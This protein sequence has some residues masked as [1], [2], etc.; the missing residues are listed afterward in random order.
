MSTHRWIL[1]LFGAFF[2]GA[3]PGA[4]EPPRFTIETQKETRH[5]C[6]LIAMDETTLRVEQAMSRLTLSGL[7]ELRQEGPGL[8]PLLTH[9]F[10]LLS[11]GDRVPLDPDASASLAV[12]RLFLW[13]AKSLPIWHEQG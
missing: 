4:Q 8:P 12:N 10:V 11:N 5:H 6:T 2:C 3:S 1:L 7:I 13:P 9:N